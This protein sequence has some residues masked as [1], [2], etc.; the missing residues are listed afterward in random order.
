MSELRDFYY[1]DSKLTD[2]YL[3]QIE[4]GLITYKHEKKINSNPDSSFEISSGKLGEVL[5]STLGIPLPDFSYTRSSKT[6]NIHI[7]EIKSSNEISRFS[8]LTRYLEPVMIEV[9]EKKNREFWNGMLENQ[10][11]KFECEIKV[12]SLYM[13]THFTRQL[14][15]PSLF[16]PENSE[17][18]DKYVEHSELIEDKKS[19]NIVL[20]PEFSLDENKYFFVS[21]IKKRFLDED[22]EL[23]DLNN[24]KFTVIGKIDKKI[25]ASGKEII[26]DLTESGM[27]NVMRSKEI[28]QFIKD[29]NRDSKDPMMRQFRVSEQDIY[30]TKPAIIFKPL[31]L[32]KR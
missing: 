13:L 32:Y 14:G 1:L 3:A 28:K 29:I 23:I 12:S 22:I 8:R 17:E 24:T 25:G 11:F 7:E 9:E 18:L 5:S 26:F 21:E 2:S 6:E 16:I 31:A 19:Q 30:A 20:K 4:D 15:K 10:F 27:L